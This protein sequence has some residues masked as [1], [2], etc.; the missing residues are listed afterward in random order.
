MSRI[1]PEPILNLP[2]VDINLKGLKAYLLQGEYCQ[3]IF[4]EFKEDVNIPEHVH[5]S[6]WEIVIE[7]KVDLYENGIKKTYKKGERFYI[8]KDVKHSAKVYAGYASIVFFN[9]KDW[10]MEKK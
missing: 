6:Q 2:E 5:E 4:I 10:Y 3:I 8:P 9:Q 7:G 1:F